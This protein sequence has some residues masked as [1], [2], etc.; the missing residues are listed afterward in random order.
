M[1]EVKLQKAVK[2]CFDNRSQVFSLVRLEEILHDEFFIKNM[3]RLAEA[4]FSN[5]ELPEFSTINNDIINYSK[6]VLK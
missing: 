2:A 4:H 6:K 3:R 1:D 5:L